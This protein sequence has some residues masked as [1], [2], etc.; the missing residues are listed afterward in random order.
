MFK[1]TGNRLRQQA[2]N[3]PLEEI[4]VGE[5]DEAAAAEEERYFRLSLLPP[6]KVPAIYP[7]P[8][9]LVRQEGTRK[10]IRR[11]E[12]SYYAEDYDAPARTPLSRLLFS[13]FFV[14]LHH[15]RTCA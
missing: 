5:D 2:K 4:Q 10:A 13:A 9:P 6:L 15:H 3:W 8:I 1:L 7:Y 11:E 14:H 12:G